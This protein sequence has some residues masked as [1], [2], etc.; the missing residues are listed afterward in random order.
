NR[1]RSARLLAS[2]IV[3]YAAE[4]RLT[5]I[6]VFA[7]ATMA[8]AQIISNVATVAIMVPIAISVFQGLGGN[9]IP[10][11]YVIIAASHCGFMLPS[12]AGSSAVAAGYGINLR[13]MFRLGF[14]AALI[15]LA[16]I[17]IV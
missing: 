14:W 17:V 2:G 6:V 1:A 10:Y 7:V 5:A 3:A 12:S 11:I 16:V 8:M 9:P 13:T 4:G 15:C